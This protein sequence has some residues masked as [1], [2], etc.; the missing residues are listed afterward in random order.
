MNVV[1]K[2]ITVFTMIMYVFVV[3]LGGHWHTLC[4]SKIMRSWRDNKWNLIS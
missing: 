3:R 4:L 2:M 1:N